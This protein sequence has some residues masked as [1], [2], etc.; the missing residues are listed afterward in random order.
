MFL[1][2]TIKKLVAKRGSAPLEPLLL[3]KGWVHGRET[4]GFQ[5]V[6]S[7]NPPALQRK[8]FSK[9][10]DCT[11]PQDFRALYM[12]PDSL[13]RYKEGLTEL[14]L[15]QLLPFSCIVLFADDNKAQLVLRQ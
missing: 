2:S 15:Y 14:A 9:D 8:G 10:R 4:A 1:Q 5:P 12:T 6:N 7:K 13:C 11:R 3:G